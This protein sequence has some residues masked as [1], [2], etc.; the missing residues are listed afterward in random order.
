[1]LWSAVFLEI[2][3][4][5]NHHHHISATLKAHHT[6]FLAPP[7]ICATF[8]AIQV[9]LQLVH[10]RALYIFMA[11]GLQGKGPEWPWAH[12][13][14]SLCFTSKSL[15]YF[16]GECGSL[17]EITLLFGQIKWLWLWLYVV[18]LIFKHR[19]HTL[20]W[21]HLRRIKA[22]YVCRLT[23]TSPIASYSTMESL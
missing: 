4:I 21:K 22:F 2:I 18:E 10:F 13:K 6:V 16:V 15:S 5:I 20:L 19:N 23:C 7:L 14:S 9:V 12:V 8:L 11:K 3:I 1:M 17:E